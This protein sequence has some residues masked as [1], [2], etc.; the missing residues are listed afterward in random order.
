MAP[1]RWKRAVVLGVH[2]GAAC[3]LGVGCQSV[4]SFDLG[5]HARS[6]TEEYPH[7]K[8]P[9]VTDTQNSNDSIVEPFFTSPPALGGRGRIVDA[10]ASAMR[11]R[12][13]LDVS[14]KHPPHPDRSCI[15]NFDPT[16]P[17]QSRGRGEE[18]SQSEETIDLGAALRLAGV[19]NPTI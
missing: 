11:V 10:N 2:L 14:V 3:W 6:L 17:P 15:R 1:R 9:T 13:L 19:E 16:S 5:P 18:D 8:T 7:L 4:E 12:G